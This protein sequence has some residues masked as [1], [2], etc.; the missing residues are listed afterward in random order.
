[1]I[2]DESDIFGEL[3]KIN[4][5][6]KLK[7]ENGNLIQRIRLSN[8]VDLIDNPLFEKSLIVKHFVIRNQ[9]YQ[10]MV[11]SQGQYFGDNIIYGS[12]HNFD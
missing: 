8:N 7:L 12:D 1:M 9:S 2:S 3:L 10:Q 11:M 6:V 5:E 4:K